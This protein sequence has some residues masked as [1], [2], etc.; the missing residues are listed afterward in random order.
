MPPRRKDESLAQSAMHNRARDEYIVASPAPDYPTHQTQEMSIDSQQRSAQE[1]REG[2]KAKGGGKKARHAAHKDENDDDVI[3]NKN[4]PD[5]IRFDGKN[6]PDSKLQR[7]LVKYGNEDDIDDVVV[8]KSAYD[9]G[10]VEERYDC[11]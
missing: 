1:R 8:F 7:G 9:R 10:R 4:V 6:E 2:Q 5:P 11:R 3:V